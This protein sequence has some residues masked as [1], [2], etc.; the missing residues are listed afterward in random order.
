MKNGL[1]SEIVEGG[2]NLSAGQRQLICIARALLRSPKILV[3]DEA[4]ASVDNE[5]DETIQNMIRERFENCSVLTIAHRLHTIIDC[6]RILVLNN[7]YLAEYESPEEL[8]SRPVDKTIM[9]LGDEDKEDKVDDDDEDINGALLKKIKNA[10]EK[11]VRPGIFKAL[12]EKHIKSHGGSSALKKVGSKNSLKS[13]D[14]KG[15]LNEDDDT[16]FA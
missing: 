11:Y 10:S 6:D 16:T 9:N 13:N 14:S 3:L 7:G 2:E 12:W 4:T 8:L 1:D 15:D 5:T